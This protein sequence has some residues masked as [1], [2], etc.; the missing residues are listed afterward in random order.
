MSVV[1]YAED[2][3]DDVFFMRLAWEG[4]EPPGSLM[5]VKDGQQAIDYLGGKGAFADRGQFPLPE[6]LLLDLKL[7]I[8]TGFEVLEWI[9]RHP[10]LTGLR[11]VVVSG[12]ELEGDVARA[13]S[14]GVLDY[15]VK[16]P[17]PARLAELVRER[18]AQWLGV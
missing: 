1:L 7:P 17:S 15:L 5:V 6:L 10:T 16:P 11:V 8:K 13:K 18:H 14:L 2:E 12:S 4:V 3:P 9:R